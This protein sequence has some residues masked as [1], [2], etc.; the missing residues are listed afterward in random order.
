MVRGAERK[1]IETIKRK[2]KRDREERREFKKM[3][4]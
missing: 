3:R 1:V 2:E 4:G